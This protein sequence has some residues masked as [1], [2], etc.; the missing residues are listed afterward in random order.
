MS[1]DDFESFSDSND[2]KVNNEGDNV[3]IEEGNA[4]KT[5]KIKKTKKTEEIRDQE[6]VENNDSDTKDIDV[7][8]EKNLFTSRNNDDRFIRE[9]EFVQ[10]L[11]RFDY[12]LFL[13]R[14][15]FFKDEKFIKYLEYLM[16]WQEL[17]Y[18]KYISYPQSLVVLRLLQKAEFRDLLNDM[19]YATYVDWLFACHN[20]HYRKEIQ[21]CPPTSIFYRGEENPPQ[22]ETKPKTKAKGKK[23]KKDKSKDG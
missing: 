8:S 9:L 15:S 23:S 11:A 12:L 22:E 6:I 5:E 7:I 4:K 13:N 14:R 20:E 3:K 21:Q 2:E 1:S 18:V 10:C 16:Y 17:P 19:E